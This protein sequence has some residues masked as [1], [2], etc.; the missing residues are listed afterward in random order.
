MGKKK[1]TVVPNLLDA[2]FGELKYELIKR[3]N[4]RVDYLR[5]EAETMTCDA[6]ELAHTLDVIEGMET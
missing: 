6:E 2:S 4:E 5:Q 1:K 3:L